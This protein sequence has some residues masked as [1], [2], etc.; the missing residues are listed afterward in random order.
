MY[1][2]CGFVYFPFKPFKHTS[3]VRTIL[4]HNQHTHAH[5]YGIL[6]QSCIKVSGS[7]VKDHRGARRRTS[8]KQH[9][10]F[11][12]SL[13]VCARTAD[14]LLTQPI[15][16][17]FL[18][19]MFFLILGLDSVSLI[20]GA[21]VMSVRMTAARA[22]MLASFPHFRSP[23]LTVQG[24]H[25][26]EHASTELRIAAWIVLAT[27]SNVSCP[28]HCNHRHPDRREL[29]RNYLVLMWLRASFMHVLKH[30]LNSLK[31]E[32]VIINWKLKQL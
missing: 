16:D 13:Q 5:L 19:P 31:G 30:A 20:S 7:D 22:F 3:W 25:S 11:P 29:V 27:C 24:T 21:R 26:A 17:M 18:I 14:V 10:A 4:Y 2:N 12:H 6:I 28:R 1:L 23:Y 8:R 9:S 32:L 15:Q